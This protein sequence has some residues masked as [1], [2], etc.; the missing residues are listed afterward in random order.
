MFLEWGNNSEKYKSLAENFKTTLLTTSS[1]FHLAN[2]IKLFI[3]KK[4]SFQNLRS[5][6]CDFDLESSFQDLRSI[7]RVFDFECDCQTKPLLKLRFL[8]FD[9]VFM[10]LRKL[11]SLHQEYKNFGPRKT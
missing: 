8:V 1:K 5:I 7:L 10:K 4:S 2:V 6:L 3:H 9:L 11:E